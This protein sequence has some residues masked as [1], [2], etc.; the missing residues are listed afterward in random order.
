MKINHIAIQVKNEENAE[1]FLT[2]VLEL[3]K[4]FGFKMDSGLAETIFGIKKDVQVETFAND[5]T[6]IE[7]FITGENVLSSF[8][9]ICLEVPDKEILIKRCGK[10][11]IVPK[12]VKRNDKELLFIRDFSGNL[13]EIKEL[14]A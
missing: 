7:V 4:V 10:Y 5:N 3:R 2:K 11:G 12:I 6:K 14:P 8:C 13:F 9:H 1:L